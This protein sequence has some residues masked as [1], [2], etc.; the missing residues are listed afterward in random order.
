MTLRSISH[1]DQESCPE[2]SH[3]G[4]TIARLGRAPDDASTLHL[5]V[6]LYL[7]RFF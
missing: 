6:T 1:H 3:A 5:L 4:S 2:Y 7:H